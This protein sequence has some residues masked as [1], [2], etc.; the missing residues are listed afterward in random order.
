MTILP[1]PIAEL[2]AVLQELVAS[3]RATLGTNF[4]GAYLQGSFAIGDWDADSDVDF[5]IAIE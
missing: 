2:N 3:V 5:S 1:T 4:I